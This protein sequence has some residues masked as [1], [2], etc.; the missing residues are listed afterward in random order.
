MDSDVDELIIGDISFAD[1]VAVL[2]PAQSRVEREIDPKVYG[3]AEWQKLVDNKNLF[4]QEIL[5]KHKI[6]ILG[7]TDDIEQPCREDY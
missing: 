1:A 7:D 6:F 5:R 3:I 4:A 2:Y